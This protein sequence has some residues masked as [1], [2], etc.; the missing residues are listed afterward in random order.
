MEKWLL[1]ES[2]YLQADG[3]ITDTF[4]FFRYSYSKTR[5]LFGGVSVEGS[6]IVERQDANA[7]AYRSD[8]SAKQLL[9]GS[10]DPPEWSSSLIKTLERCTGM[11]GGRQWV[12][13]D[14]NLRSD[15]AFGGFASPENGPSR[16]VGQDPL[17]ANFSGGGKHS[18]KNS[19]PPSSWGKKKDS[20]SYF[21][22]EFQDDLNNT[23]SPPSKPY[24]SSRSLAAADPFS[25]SSNK[26]E[27]HFDSDF[28]SQE[29]QHMKQHARFGSSTLPGS[30]AAGYGVTNGGASSYAPSPLVDFGSTPSPAT[31][32]IP[33]ARSMSVASPFSGP[34]SPSTNPF[35]SMAHQRSASLAAPPPYI[36]PKP[37]LATPLSPKD[38]VA[39]AIALYHFQAVESGDLSFNKGEVITI[40]EKSDS[41]D[42][43][44][45]I[46]FYSW[47]DELCC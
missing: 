33:H 10:I 11:P 2:R 25:G 21:D 5:G 42:D 7:Q 32:S 39:R 12:N 30:N 15:Y 14:D 13:D 43:W 44:Y 18:K 45:V 23:S 36:Q 1:C 16:S 28:S 34:K 8:V 24:E 3:F 4:H 38:G 9:S 17:M 27:T 29:Q 46:P 20:G 35:S 22:S 31:Q 47:S 40:I 26:F 19:F 37:E 6:V 41:S